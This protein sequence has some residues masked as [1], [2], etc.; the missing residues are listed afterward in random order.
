VSSRIIGVVICTTLL[1]ASCGKSD[2]PGKL[3][4]NVAR[5]V[6]EPQ[7]SQGM[8]GGNS[9]PSDA[10]TSGLQTAAPGCA[11]GRGCAEAEAG[12]KAAEP[13]AGP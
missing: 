9:G 12:A 7:K 1:A 4:E 5:T 13:D 8:F 11:E 6:G 10:S 2:P 3:E